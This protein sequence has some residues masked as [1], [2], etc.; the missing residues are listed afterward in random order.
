MSATYETLIL[1]QPILSRTQVEPEYQVVYPLGTFAG[2]I[3]KVLYRCNGSIV[4]S[5]TSNQLIAAGLK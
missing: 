5:D 2:S 1:D 3:E 4:P